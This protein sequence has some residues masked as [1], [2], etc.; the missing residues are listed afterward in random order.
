MT[1]EMQ[2]WLGANMFLYEL[3]MVHTMLHDPERRTMLLGAELTHEDFTD[4]RTALLFSAIALGAKTREQLGIRFPL[5]PTIE[6]IESNASA[7]NKE[8]AVATPPETEDALAFAVK[9]LDPEY[10]KEDWHAVESYYDGWYGT[11]AMKK[12]SR[13]VQGSRV[14]DPGEVS[15]LFSRAATR[16]SGVFVTGSDDLEAAMQDVAEDQTERFSTGFYQL[17]EALCGGFATKEAGLIFGGTNAGKTALATQITAHLIG[18]AA[19]A[20]IMSTEMPAINYLAR[21]AANRCNI[22]IGKLINCRN[23]K[24][25]EMVVAQTYSNRLD[26]LD[27]LKHEIDSY[28]G[29]RKLDPD[30]TMSVRGVLENEYRR[31]EKVRGV[32]PKVMLFDWM[33][34]LADQQES[35][36]SGDRSANWERQADEY[37]K[38]GDKFDV[39][40]IV[41]AQSV[42]NAQTF[43]VQGVDQIGIG[44]GIAKPMTWA[45]AITSYV[46][47]AAF[48]AAAAGQGDAPAFTIDEDQALC[49]AKN[50]NGASIP[51][52]PVTRKNL[53][54]QR[55][56]APAP[57]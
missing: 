22:S 6:F 23:W 29:F 51:P 18:T 36:S 45:A 2:Q 12:I 33:G 50:R 3:I 42:N 4:V 7:V 24:Q 54:Y 38:F 21:M 56:Q 17:D 11:S 16:A 35:K 13:K 14:I 43:R 30:S 52:I 37:V 44:K 46:D 39:C 28:F 31:F 32:P 27:N 19:P 48:R 34:R 53:K 20:D 47:Q 26:A 15:S 55:F 10:L 40:M 9:L 49:L 41:L 57:K 25:I 8:E 1:K 5:K